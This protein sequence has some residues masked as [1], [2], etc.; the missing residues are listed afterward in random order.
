MAYNNN[1]PVNQL[2]MHLARTVTGLAGTVDFEH[3]VVPAK[4]HGLS[5]L[6]R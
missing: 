3:N 6:K 2:A 5:A 4:A 1:D